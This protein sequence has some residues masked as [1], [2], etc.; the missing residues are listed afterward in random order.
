MKNVITTGRKN[1]RP[2]TDAFSAWLTK[3]N[4]ERVEDLHGIEKYIMNVEIQNDYTL[5]T[6]FNGSN[7][8]T[9]RRWIF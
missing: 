7:Y 2:T 6:T 8:S 5:V 4:H 1:S 3:R 9:K